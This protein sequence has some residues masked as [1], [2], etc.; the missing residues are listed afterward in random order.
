MVRVRGGPRGFT[1]IELLVVIAII[2]TLMA[3]LLPAVQKVREAAEKMRCASNIRQVHLAAMNYENSL[4]RLPPGYLGYRPVGKM[5]ITNPFNMLSNQWVSVL[6]Q[7]LPYIEKN[8]AYAYLAQ[9]TITTSTPGFSLD[10]D[11]PIDSGSTI[12]PT[13]AWWDLSPSWV[14]AQYQ[15]KIFRC[16]SDK[17]AEERTN[18]TALLHNGMAESDGSGPYIIAFYFSAGGEALGRTNYMGVAG[19]AGKT[20]TATWDQFVGVFH[21]RSKV[22]IGEIVDGVSNTLFFGECRGNSQVGNTLYDNWSHSWMGAGMLPVRYGGVPT[23]EPLNTS[24]FFAQPQRG[25]MSFSSNH[26]AGVHFVM[27][28][29]A[30]RTIRRGVSAVNIL[31]P[32]AGYRDRARFNETGWVF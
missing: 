4:G 22:K 1:L 17:T 9:A 30:V 20:G 24:L 5:N 2:V 3:I 15:V 27:G 25:Y 26:P 11:F 8:D 12:T 19:A 29:G 31:Q 16:P 32:M 6:G 21:N 14:A 18:V 28:D 10:V 13:Y 7:L 23:E